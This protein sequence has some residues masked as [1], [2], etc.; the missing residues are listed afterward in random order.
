[1][2]ETKQ[3][4]LLEAL[5]SGEELT[6]SQISQRFG[7]KNPTA[8]VSDLRFAGFAVYANQRKGSNG[9]TTTKYRLG[10]PSRK[11]VAAGYRALA[12]GITA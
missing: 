12:M 2:K 11:V 7:I 6:A 1:M 8:T 9:E 10:T 3:G 5:R 4:R